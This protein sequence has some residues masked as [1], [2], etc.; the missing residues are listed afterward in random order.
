MTQMLNVFKHLSRSTRGIR[1]YSQQVAAP[2]REGVSNATPQVPCHLNLVRH[3][4]YV[5]RNSRGSLPVYSDMRNNGTRTLVLIRN[6]QG[7]VEKLAKDVT[8]ALLNKGSPGAARMKVVV[9]SRQL[10][11]QDGHWKNDVIEWLITKGF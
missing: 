1:C 7:N 6:V 11:L 4:Y 3:P 8:Q 9:K 10:V 5:P 2:T